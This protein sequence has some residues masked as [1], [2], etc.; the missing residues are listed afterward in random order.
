MNKKFLI[1]SLAIFCIGSITAGIVIG[2]DQNKSG[3]MIDV[4]KP[5]S[6]LSLFTTGIT[7]GE[8]ECY[9]SNSKGCVIGGNE[10]CNILF[11]PNGTPQ[12]ISCN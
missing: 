11:S 7:D 1:L 2:D 12:T 3:V 9:H 8:Y 5:T 6:F 4:P 10:T